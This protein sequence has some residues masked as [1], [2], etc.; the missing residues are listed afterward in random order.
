MEARCAGLHSSRAPACPV[1]PLAALCLRGGA[2]GYPKPAA[3][4]RPIQGYAG[5]DRQCRGSILAVLRAAA[6][7]VTLTEAEAA[8]ADGPQRARAVASLLADGLV[9]PAGQDGLALP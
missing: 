7:P 3:P 4:R 2:S 6:G 8:W 5:T 9:V 1:C